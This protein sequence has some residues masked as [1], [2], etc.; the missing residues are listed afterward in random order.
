M[1]EPVAVIPV[2]GTIDHAKS[3]FTDHKA[4]IAMRANKWIV[5]LWAALG[6]S[7]LLLAGFSTI[8][9]Q[10]DPIFATVGLS[11]DWIDFA[12]GAVACL[13][14]LAWYRNWNHC[15]RIGNVVAILFGGYAI[16]YLVIGGE[17]HWFYRYLA[18]FFIL[19]LSAMTLISKR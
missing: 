10:T 15:R 1:E 19:G 5:A 6:V 4:H 14:A 18:P 2:G 16:S 9:W 17:G 13:V 11:W 3:N 7:L 12:A 8:K